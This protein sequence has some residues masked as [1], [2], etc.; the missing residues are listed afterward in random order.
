MSFVFLSHRGI[1]K[2]RIRPFVL[3][4][5]KR[6]VPVWIDRPEEF[7]LGLSSGEMPIVRDA[8]CGGIAL[9][10]DWPQQI[11]EALMQAF[12]IVVFWSKNWTR[13]REVL[14]REHGAAHMFHNANYSTY[15]PVMLDDASMLN[16]AVVA[17]RNAVHDN[18]QA[19]NVARFGKEHWDA[20]IDRV[21]A[22]WQSQRK[23]KVTSQLGWAHTYPSIDWVSELAHQPRDPVRLVELLDMLPPGPAVD[24]FILPIEIHWAFA[25]SGSEVEARLLV[26]EADALVLQTF[27]APLRS[28]PE[29]LVVMPTAVPSPFQVSLQQYWSEVLAHACTLGPRMVAALLLSIRPAALTRIQPQVV[30]VLRQ[31]EV[32]R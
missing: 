26:S 9:A 21:L 18:V 16:P 3:E 28:V 19:F 31:L 7:N 27:S 13:D 29:R 17:Y 6:G 23:V 22:L 2:P 32:H 30:Q 11:D 25:K 5:I 4:L 8:L 15:L 10:S 24:L 20:L 1:D 14:T 12:A